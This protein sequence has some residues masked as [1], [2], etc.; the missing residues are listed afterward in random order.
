MSLLR[1]G[2]IKQH[3]PSTCCSTKCLYV[4][5]TDKH[6]PAMTWPMYCIGWLEVKDLQQAEEMFMKSFDYIHTEFQV[7]YSLVF[8]IFYVL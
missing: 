6:G 5:V 7:S 4:Q 8:V 3:Q 1:Q 2:V